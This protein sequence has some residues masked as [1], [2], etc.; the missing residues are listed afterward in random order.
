M[1]DSKRGWHVNSEVIYKGA[2][3][4]VLLW[5]SGLPSKPTS[6][7]DWLVDRSEQLKV[8][9]AFFLFCLIYLAYRV[10]FRDI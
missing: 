5:K 1:L 2:N 3:G 7:V 6:P 10:I 4:W 9:S 8:P